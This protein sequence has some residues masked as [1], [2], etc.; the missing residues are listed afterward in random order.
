[1][2]NRAKSP[3]DKSHKLK[4]SDLRVSDA[5]RADAI[6]RLRAH[7]SMGH[8]EETEARH[9]VSVVEA[10]K[11]PDEIA[12]LF[13][14]LP[15]LAAR[16]PSIERRVSSRDRQDAIHL[17]EKA[18][19]EGRI[20][21]EECAA[22]KDRVHAARTR[23]EIEAAFHGL[24]TPTRV[25]AEE[26]AVKA[27]TQTATFTARAF[28]QIRRRTG[29]AF[30][31]AVFAVGALLIGIVLAVAGIGAGALISFLCAVLLFVS[32]AIALVTS[33]S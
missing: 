11:T 30:R 22:A 2:F 1:M 28:V 25:V 5:D 13:A 3:E 31:R 6:R 12:R 4:V 8:L 23:T 18:Y 17:L 10:S 33:T 19:S 20:E 26:R 7:E 16:P 32:A 15:A 9:R 14:D 24:S 27:A 29:K 21:P